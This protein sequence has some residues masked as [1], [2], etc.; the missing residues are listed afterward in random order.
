MSP[1]PGPNLL[2][3]ELLCDAQ[4]CCDSCSC[5]PFRS[6]S[7]HTTFIQPLAL[8][9]GCTHCLQAAPFFQVASCLSPL[10]WSTVVT[11]PS[12][13]CKS[14]TATYSLWHPARLWAALKHSLL[15]SFQ[16]WLLSLVSP[17]QPLLQACCLC[18]KSLLRLFQPRVRF[19]HLSRFWNLREMFHKI[20]PHL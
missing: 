11:T 15:L 5:L 14:L 7:F 4:G 9:P 12:R 16:S 3:N 13:I 20:F 8:C 10:A 17:P 6:R 1:W 18:A 2:Y 19:S